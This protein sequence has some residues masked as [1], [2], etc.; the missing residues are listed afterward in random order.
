MFYRFKCG[1]FIEAKSFKQAQDIFKNQISFETEE[2]KN[3]S[4]CTC[5][6]LNHRFS[7]P[8]NPIN[9]SNKEVAF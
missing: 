2:S 6:G 1:I 8:E 4:S 5:L 9:N 7:C 3:W